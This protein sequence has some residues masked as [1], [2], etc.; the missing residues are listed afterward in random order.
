MLGVKFP[1]WLPA[2]ALVLI[3]SLA[4]ARADLVIV[5]KVE[6]GGLEGEMT[7]KFH[8]KKVRAD[9]ALP[10]SLLLDGETGDSVLLQHRAKTFNRVTA[11][12][13]KA[14]MDKMVAAQAGSEPPKLAPINEKKDIAGHHTDGFLWTVG[15]MKIRF[16]VAKDFPNA[17]A[18]QQQLSLLQK[19]GL[20]SAAAG[21]MPTAE[22][23]PGVRLRTEFEVGGTK[24]VSTILSIKEETLDA[25][26]FEIPPGY[27][28]V[29]VPVNGAGQ[30]P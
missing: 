14:L 15:Q 10:V 2:A 1:L 5:Q 20:G 24:V 4:A 8:E 22:Q 3:G 17:D 6:G 26:L 29:L 12:E 23:L 27:K 21:L 16:F 11:A 9:L 30:E 28:E 7:I 13:T 18:I 25:G 19:S